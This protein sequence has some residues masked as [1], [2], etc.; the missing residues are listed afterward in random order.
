MKK[1]RAQHEKGE[2]GKAVPQEHVLDEEAWF[3]ENVEA[4]ECGSRSCGLWRG[5]PGVR[6]V[7][8]EKGKRN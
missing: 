7:T 8:S 6:C 2:R 4:K 3:N 5:K 1:E